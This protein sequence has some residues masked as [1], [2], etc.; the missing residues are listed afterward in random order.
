MKRL[1]PKGGRK[2]GRKIHPS[3]VED[4]IRAAFRLLPA[5]ILFLVAGLGPEDRELL[6]Y[7]VTV[8]VEGVLSPEEAA[9]AGVPPARGRG[10]YG[11]RVGCT[12][13]ALAPHA[14]THGCACFECYISFWARL[15][16]SAESNR[17]QDV[18]EAYEYHRL[19]L[20]SS[21][22][23]RDRGKRSK[24]HAAPLLLPPPLRRPESPPPQ[25]VEAVQAPASPLPPPSC[26]PPPPLPPAQAPAAP[27]AEE[28]EEEQKF[29]PELAPAAE[30]EECREL[31]VESGEEERKR[32]WAGVMG[33][34]LGLRLWSIWSPAVESAT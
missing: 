6:A 13:P 11:R 7:F 33:G 27:A 1:S 8:P 10:G 34:V 16:C 25:V 4:P 18:L 26:L 31:A 17:I 5:A 29:V 23:R 9:A 30:P 3:P 20:A 21:S 15:N 24:D 28:E 19:A 14:P 22:K 32:G 12:P 2:G